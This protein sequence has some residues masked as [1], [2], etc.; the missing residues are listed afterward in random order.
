MAS[1]QL[2]AL[3][4]NGVSPAD[5]IARRKMPIYSYV[6]KE[7]LSV[8]TKERLYF[9]SFILKLLFLCVGFISI[10]ELSA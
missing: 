3:S 7:W 10:A 8:G 5:A 4:G 9:V 6:L 2:M 1:A